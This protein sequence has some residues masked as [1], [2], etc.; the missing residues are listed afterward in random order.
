MMIEIF[1]E[2]KYVKVHPYLLEGIKRAEI[3]DNGKEER[4]LNL[5]RDQ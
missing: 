3:G 1:V 5:P 2:L 4:T